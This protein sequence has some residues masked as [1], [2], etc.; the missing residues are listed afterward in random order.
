MGP[1]G[2]PGDP[3]APIAASQGPAEA[4]GHYLTF[5]DILGLAGRRLF[6][7]TNFEQAPS[8][9]AASEGKR[10]MKSIAELEHVSDVP[11][12]VADH[13]GLITRINRR[14]QSVFGW[15]E[16]EIIGKPLT[17]LIPKRLRDAHHLGFSRFLTTS[18]ATL[19]DRPLRLR[20]VAKDGVEF[21]A[22]HYIIAEKGPQGWTFGATIRP[23]EEKTDAD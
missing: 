21:D 22:E 2:R 20:A 16:G 12:V 17:I 14:F 6:G 10:T 1:L 4:F 8:A 9:K 19:L 18:Q 7:Y 3:P 5:S 15:S 11:V 23:L 13:Q